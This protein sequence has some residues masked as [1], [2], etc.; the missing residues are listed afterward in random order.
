MPGKALFLDRDGIINVDTGYVSKP[1]QVTFVA[2]IF[3]V[4]AR[5]VAAGYTPVIVT[6]QSGIG[7]GMYT[8]TDFHQLS[9]WMQSQF[10]R[11][12]LPAIPVYYCPHH[13]TE[14]IAGYLQSCACRK[15]EPGMILQATRDHGLALDESLLIGDSWRDIQAADAAG[16]SRKVFVSTQAKPAQTISGVLQV[17]SVSAILDADTLAGLL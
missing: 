12:G 5:F 11:Q 6:N 4:I 2:G 9:E 10:T 1:Q 15:P 16:V 13:P 17:G 3:E 8:E 7:R 14:A